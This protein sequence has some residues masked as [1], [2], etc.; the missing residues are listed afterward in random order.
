MK[1]LIEIHLIRALMCIAIVLTHS[2]SNYLR[3]VEMDIY[4]YE[5][6]II[7]I[8]F[9]LLCSTSIFILLSETLLS[10]NYPGALKRG[11]FEKRIKFILVPYLLIGLIVSYRGSNRVE[12]SS[13]L[14]LAYKKIILG[15]WYGFFVLV[16]FQL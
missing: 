5:Q 13:F 4:A 10:R 3:N 8:Q 9:A 1:N 11:F 12:F 16:I 2:I 15:E 7:Y 6:Y 14:E